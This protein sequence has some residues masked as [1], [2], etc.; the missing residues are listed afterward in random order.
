MAMLFN[1]NRAY[2]PLVGFQSEMYFIL[3]SSLF[4]PNLRQA[5]KPAL[6]NGRLRAYYKQSDEDVAS[7]VDAASRRTLL[8][9]LLT[10]HYTPV[11][12][13]RADRSTSRRPSGRIRDDCS[14]R[15]R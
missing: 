7:T 9:K 12:I 10:I 2:P 1:V 15:I 8:I 11:T 5:G 14:F 3:F 4:K 13:S 6:K